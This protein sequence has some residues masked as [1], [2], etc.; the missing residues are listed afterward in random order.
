MKSRKFP[1][2]EEAKAYME[3]AGVVKFVGR[4]GD[5]YQTY[6]YTLTTG[7]KIYQIKL[8]QD[9]HLEVFHERYE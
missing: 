3:K 2:F 5:Q 6:I 1:T 7:S 8:S 9:G 4:D